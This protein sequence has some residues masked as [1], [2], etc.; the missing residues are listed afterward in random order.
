MLTQLYFL[1]FAVSFSS[2]Q[3]ICGISDWDNGS[4]KQCCKR[5]KK[6]K[7]NSEAAEGK[8]GKQCTKGPGPQSMV[9]RKKV[10]KLEA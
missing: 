2:P 8:W 6:I 4:G 3:L 9:N 1:V 10:K 7:H 5:D